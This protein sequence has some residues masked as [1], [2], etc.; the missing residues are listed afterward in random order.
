V[1]AKQYL[2]KDAGS[3]GSEWSNAVI[4]SVLMREG[5]MKEAREA[6]EKMTT[7]PTWMREFLLGC[8][9]RGP[10]TEVHRLAV[11]AQ[12]EL[13]PE[14]DPEL[15]YYQGALL[16]ACGEKQIAYVFL[17]KAVAENYCAHQALQSDPLLVSVRGDTEFQKIV[18]AAAE[19]QQKAQ[20]IR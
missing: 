6:A 1:F 9:S 15:K 17:R 18:Q 11:L 20:G 16:A 7:N 13:L 12:N 19:C 2:N 10:A 5:R 14:Q 4:V 8:L 3:A